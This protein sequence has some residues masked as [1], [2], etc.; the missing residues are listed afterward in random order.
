MGRKQHLRHGIRC[1]QKNVLGNMK[2]IRN[3]DRRNVSK[4]ME[5]RLKWIEG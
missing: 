5:K 4:I 2:V 1:G 3:P